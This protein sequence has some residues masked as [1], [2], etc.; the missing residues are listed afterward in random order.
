MLWGTEW[1]E[2]E[3]LKYIQTFFACEFLDFL[4]PKISAL[5]D[6]GLIWILVGF[7]M[8]ASKKHRKT[9]ALLLIGLLAGLLVGNVI[10]KNLFQRP[11]PCWLEPELLR[12]IQSPTD[13]SFPSGHTLSSFIA[14]FTIFFRHKKL[15]SVAILLASLIAFSRMYLFVHFP[16]DILGGI[17]L[18]FGISYGLRILSRKKFN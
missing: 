15:G 9:G 4:M 10:L 8:L 13:F 7:L 6:A 2:I 1:F 12:L 11:R 14:A 16:T 5:G 17:L 3:I 18:A